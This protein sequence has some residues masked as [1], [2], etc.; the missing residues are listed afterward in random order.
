LIGYLEFWHLF[1]ILFVDKG[2]QGEAKCLTPYKGSSLP[3][4]KEAFNEVFY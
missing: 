2:Y 1:E 3:P 4:D